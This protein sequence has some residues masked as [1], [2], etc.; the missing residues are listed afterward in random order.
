MADGTIL[1]LAVSLPTVHVDKYG[2]H[3]R[4]PSVCLTVILHACKRRH[5]DLT[6]SK[7]EY[8]LLVLASKRMCRISDESISVREP[9]RLGHRA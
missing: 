2:G 9:E 4:A 5:R 1:G 3:A 6:T 8:E 7:G